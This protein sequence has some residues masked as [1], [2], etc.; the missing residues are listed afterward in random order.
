[1][2][3][4]LALLLESGFFSADVCSQESDRGLSGGCAMLSGCPHELERC[5]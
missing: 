1:V 5:M 4:I 2:S 3:P